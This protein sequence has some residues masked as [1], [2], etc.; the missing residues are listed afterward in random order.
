MKQITKILL[1]LFV[2]LFVSSLSAQDVQSFTVN[3]LKVIFKQNT[4]NDII[5]SNLYY[6]GGVTN[7]TEDKAGLEALTLVVS[8]KSSINYPKDKLNAALESMNTVI[9]TNSNFDFF[10]GLACFV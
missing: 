2:I 10:Q 1:I 8:T 6:K 4:A 9:N 5:S 7:L 3:G